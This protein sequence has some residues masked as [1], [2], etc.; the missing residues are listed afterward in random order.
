VNAIVT[1][2]LAAGGILKLNGADYVTIDGANTTGGTTQNLTIENS[3]AT[4]S[5][6]TVVW[7]AAASAADGATFNTVKNTNI[8]GNSA[9]GFP[10]FTVFLGGGGVNVAAPTTSTPAPN[11]NNTISNNL[12]QKGYYGVFV[13]GPSATNMDQSNVIS[14]NQL[15]QGTGNGFGQEG[16][17]VVYQQN[18]LVERNEIQNLTNGTTTANLYGIFLADSKNATVNRNSVHNISYTGTSTTKVWAINTS[19]G[20]FSTAANA[21][22]LLL[23]NN[24]VYNINST[25]TS[26]TYNTSGINLNG[27][28][29]DRVYFNTVYLTG[30]LSAASGTSASAA[31]SNGNPSVTTISTN[32][33]V[34]NNIFSIIGGTGGTTTPRCMPT[35]PKAP[36]PC[37]L[38]A[39]STTTTCS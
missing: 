27:G 22:A 32:V 16:L 12:I 5:G 31:F 34:R 39:P 25:A 28:F 4:G 24:L 1:G 10:Q 19:L 20:A 17:R 37:L 18:L 9:T 36:A 30:Q 23:S 11:S 6:N 29:G 38:A 15:G 8:R 21:S 13:F 35:T 7:I 2:S 3:S 26:A 33:D 14:G